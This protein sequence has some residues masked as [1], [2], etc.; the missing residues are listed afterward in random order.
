MSNLKKIIS[1]AFNN[2]NPDRVANTLISRVL[3]KYGISESTLKNLSPDQ[4]EKIRKI[5]SELQ[6]RINKTLK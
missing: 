5:T 6:S 4:K 3:D 2:P 1:S